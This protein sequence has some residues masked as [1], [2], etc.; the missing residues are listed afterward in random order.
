MLPR[1]RGCPQHIAG[2]LNFWES[3]CRTGGGA[4][5][6]ADWGRACWL[7]PRTQASAAR[8]K[9]ADYPF[10]TLVPNLGVVELDFR[11]AVWCDIPG[12]LEGA[13]AGT[14]LG[15]EFL[16]HCQRCRCPPRRRGPPP[17]PPWG[18]GRASLNLHHCRELI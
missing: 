9:I 3:D 14:G 18:G 16:R 13:H 7:G 4:A 12:L 1:H 6:D 17:P 10:T 11:S 15:H 8:P 2:S 5:A